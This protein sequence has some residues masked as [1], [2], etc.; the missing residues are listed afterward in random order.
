LIIS[1]FPALC[2]GQAGKVAHDR[3]YPFSFFFPLGSFF[4]R[5][6]ERKNGQGANCVAVVLYF[7]QIPKQTMGGTCGIPR[8][9]GTYVCE[10]VLQKIQAGKEKWDQGPV[11][12][13]LAKS[14]E[15]KPVFTTISGTPVERLY[16][17]LDVQGLDYDR[18][19]SFPGQFPYT[20]GVQ[21]TMYRGRY[22]TMRQYA[23][24]GDAKGTNERYRYCS[25]RVRRASAWR[26]YATQAATNRHPSRWVSWE[27]RCGDRSHH[28]WNSFQR[29]SPRKAPLR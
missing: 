25:T 29:H 27:S 3:F 26:S 1:L 24:F 6:C 4:P 14:P 8:W 21:P 28:D 15:A 11:A 18:D 12:K 17:P 23:G 13:T 5:V 2:C 19:L 10:K 7:K 9:E 20:R 16:T 22:W